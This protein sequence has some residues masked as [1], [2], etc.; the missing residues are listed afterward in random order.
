MKKLFTGL[1]CASLAFVLAVAVGLLPA[2]AAD[3]GGAAG[4][5]CADLEERVAELEATTVKKGNRKV[6]V[7]VS[8]FVSHQIMYWNDGTQSDAYIGDG[9]NMG[10]RFRFV[11]TAKITPT[12][13]AGFLYEFG[14][15][16]NA[17]GSMNQLNGGDDL[18][19]ALSV[20]Q[21]TVWVEHQALGRLTI[22]HGSTATDD[23][24]LIDLSGASAA[25]T[26]DVALFNGGMFLRSGGTL[27]ALTPTIGATWADVLNRRTSFDTARRNSIMWTS[28]D[29]VGFQIKAAMGEDD[30]WDVALR[31]SGEM[32]GFRFAAG[33]GYS[34]DSDAAGMTMPFGLGSVPAGIDVKVTELKGS[35]SVLHIAS[36]IFVT[37]A[38]GMRETSSSVLSGVGVG[39]SD[40][41][42]W[43]VSAG[44][45]KNWFGVGRTVAY[46]EYHEAHGMLGLTI[47]PFQ[48]DSAARMIGA[49][50][51]Q[52]FD[53]AGMELFLAYKRF[54]A[55]LETSVG[56]ISFDRWDAIIAGARLTF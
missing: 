29:L 21:S 50:L 25:M 18:G 54:E 40:A 24:V 1:M 5:C 16:N 15:A 34:V 7:T 12:V 13:T 10:S 2:R 55:D 41:D 46:G 37:G 9:G 48:T 56:G 4:G 17:I 33:I 26:A 51:V 44:I 30:F 49:G 8:G 38:Y 6:S 43:H 31:Y 11:G 20:R 47:G 3:T 36:G 45:S 19:G 42:F 39:I 52:H 14:M 35:G 22:G 28:P 27:L 32:A 53:N 23:I